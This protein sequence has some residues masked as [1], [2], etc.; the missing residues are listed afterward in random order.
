MVNLVATIEPTTRFLKTSMEGFVPT[1][2]CGKNLVVGLLI[3]NGHKAQPHNNERLDL[4]DD[5]EQGL[6]G[7][8]DVSK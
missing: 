2:R 8:L 3:C 7:L 6:L 5:D 1:I 4:N